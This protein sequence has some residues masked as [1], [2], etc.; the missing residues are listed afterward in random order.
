MLIHSVCIDNAYRRRGLARALLQHYITECK[1]PSFTA[2]ILVC[3]PELLPLY[4][5]VGF[6]N[7]GLSDLIHGQRPWHQMRL[8]IHESSYQ[9][10]PRNDRDLICPVS[11]C[12]C[13]ILKAGVGSLI[14]KE[15][16]PVSDLG[17]LTDH[18][19]TRAISECLKLEDCFD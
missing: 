13:V 1:S 17:C 2:L 16:S 4:Q 7:A 6:K 9:T 19:D 18:F 10:P 15:T 3:H 8:D 11:Q 14:E 12:R 5:A